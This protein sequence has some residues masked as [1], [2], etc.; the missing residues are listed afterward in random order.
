MI[1]LQADQQPPNRVEHAYVLSIDFP[2]YKQGTYNLQ[3]N[4]KPEKKSDVEVPL[5]I[6]R[7]KCSS[8]NGYVPRALN[9]QAQIH[10]QLT[11]C[12]HF[13]PR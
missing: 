10:T 5:H 6:M 4:D 9:K 8:G 12:P 11:Q 7:S 2:D 1:C 3:A 13:W